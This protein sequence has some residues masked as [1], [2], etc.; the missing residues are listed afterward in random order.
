[1]SIPTSFNPLGTLGG[2]LPYVQPVK[3]GNGMTQHSSEGSFGF[4]L[5]TEG[6]FNSPWKAFADLAPG[7][8][9]PYGEYGNYSKESW[10]E[11]TFPEGRYLKIKSFSCLLPG[12][13]ASDRKPHTL[14]LFGLNDDGSES[15]LGDVY[16]AQKEE[17]GQP[18]YELVVASPAYYHSYKFVATSNVGFWPTLKDMKLNA[19][20][21]P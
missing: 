4:T 8:S 16:L 12:G 9:S 10:F 3:T 20:Y 11:M 15:K 19:V 13:T 17:N 7:T 5:T 21:K 14:S 6:H 2:E 1:M 18:R